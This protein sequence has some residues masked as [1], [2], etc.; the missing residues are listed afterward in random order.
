MF[1]SQ[2][3]EYYIKWFDATFTTE[4][5]A[6]VFAVESVCE[7]EQPRTGDE[8]VAMLRGKP[9]SLE[10]CYGSVMLYAIPA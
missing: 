10:K 8:V 1:G 5:G 3:V 7:G 9:E 2:C 4:D 6:A